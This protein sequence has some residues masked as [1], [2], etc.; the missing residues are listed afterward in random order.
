MSATYEAALIAFLEGQIEEIRRER[1]EEE[2]AAGPGLVAGNVPS[3]PPL[4]L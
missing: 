4:F 3:V 2:G 1:E